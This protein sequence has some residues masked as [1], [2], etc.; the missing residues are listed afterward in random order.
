MLYIM[1]SSAFRVQALEY[2][3]FQ[4]VYSKTYCCAREISDDLSDNIIVSSPHLYS[5]KEAIFLWFI[6]L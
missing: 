4:F 6:V 3:L 2:P 5:Q 1:S